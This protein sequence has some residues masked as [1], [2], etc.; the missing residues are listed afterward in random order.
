MILSVLRQ[1]NFEVFFHE[2]TSFCS[3]NF[4]KQPPKINNQLKTK[5]K[6]YFRINSYEITDSLLL[7]LLLNIWPLF[8]L[9]I[10]FFS[11]GMQF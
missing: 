10:D 11:H 7:S 4:T 6:C 9:A 1:A 5:K 2:A 3:D 8:K